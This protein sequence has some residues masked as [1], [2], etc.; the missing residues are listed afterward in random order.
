MKKSLFIE[1]TYKK[2]TDKELAPIATA[3]DPLHSTR[4]PV[5]KYT[6]K[7]NLHFIPATGNMTKPWQAIVLEGKDEVFPVSPR[8]FLGLGYVETKL[9]EVMPRGFAK[10]PLMNLIADGKFQV[11]ITGYEPV[12]VDDFDTKVLAA[13][14]YPVIKKLGKNDAE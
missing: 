7:P 6:V 9:V 2:V 11:E 3:I 12:S 13:K 14:D 5:G 4:V 10:K 1:S 8:V